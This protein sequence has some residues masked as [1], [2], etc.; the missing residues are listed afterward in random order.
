MFDE[1]ELRAMS[2]QER[3]R[4]LHALTEI[5]GP[6]ADGPPARSARAGR[7]RW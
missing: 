4:L 6:A 1:E 3:I 5:D 7:W 2:P